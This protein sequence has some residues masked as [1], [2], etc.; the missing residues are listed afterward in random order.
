[1]AAKFKPLPTGIINPF[2]PSFLESWE[3]WKNYRW[4]EHKFKYKGVFSEQAALMKLNDLSSGDEEKAKAI[5]KQ[6]M[7][8]PWKGLFPLKIEKNG[9]TKA[10]TRQEIN[11]EFASRPYANGKY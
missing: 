10:P 7:E 8:G 1:M 4:D 3:L 2:T 9:H 11:T 6:S 5:I